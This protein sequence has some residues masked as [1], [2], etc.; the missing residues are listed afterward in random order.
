MTAL[1]EKIK[2]FRDN[3]ET[4]ETYTPEMTAMLIEKYL[5]RFN[6]EL[7]EITSKNQVGQRNS[8]QHASRQDAI[9]LTNKL[10][11]DEYE[12]CGFGNNNCIMYFH[13]FHFL[14]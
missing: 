9:E 11:R 4:G 6:A 5:G 7:E 2:W 8:R 13:Y 10:E 12:G 14:L 3:L 1:C